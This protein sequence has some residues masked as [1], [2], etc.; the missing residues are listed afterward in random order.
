[1]KNIVEGFGE[2]LMLLTADADHQH[3]QEVKDVTYTSNRGHADK[4]SQRTKGWQKFCP[5]AG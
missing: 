1:M 2:K 3:E 5:H 4:N